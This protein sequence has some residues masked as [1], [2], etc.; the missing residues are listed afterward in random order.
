MTK[1]ALNTGLG[2]FRRTRSRSSCRAGWSAAGRSS[3]NPATA[4]KAEEKKRGE[5][6]RVVTQRNAAA[7]DLFGN[8][9]AYGLH[10]SAYS[11]APDKKQPPA[12]FLSICTKRCIASI[13]PPATRPQNAPDMP[14]NVTPEAVMRKVIAAA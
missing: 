9:G 8:L 11:R 6:T 1:A 12:Y 5:G 7:D 3:K 13:R 14:A 10:G 2:K 4:C